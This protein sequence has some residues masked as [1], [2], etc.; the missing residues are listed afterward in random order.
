MNKTIEN[1]LRKILPLAF[2]IFFIWLG[3]RRTDLFSTHFI[4]RFKEYN[5]SYELENLSDINEVKSVLSR[6]FHYLT[7]GRECFIFESEDK[8]YIL[9][10]FD[11]TRYYTKIYV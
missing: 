7:R 3:Y 1:I 4:T 2:L 10:F 9:K 8:K 5:K 6:K 11:S